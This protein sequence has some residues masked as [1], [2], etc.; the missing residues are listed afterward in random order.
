MC[1]KID[2]ERKNNWHRP[3]VFKK[4]VEDIPVFKIVKSDGN[5]AFYAWYNF[6][7][8]ELGGTYMM[9][10][11]NEIEPNITLGFDCIYIYEAFHSYSPSKINLYWHG[12]TLFAESAP[13]MKFCD[14]FCDNFY[15]NVIY[16]LDC[17]VPKGAMY[18]EN[19]HGEI[20]SDM[21]RVISYKKLTPRMN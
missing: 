19:A 4:A 2:V 11:E 1:L 9:S 10:L 18:A 15:S 5:D 3:N 6:F 20:A 7:K 17:V 13:T 8:Y 14:K 21:I 16:R 12:S